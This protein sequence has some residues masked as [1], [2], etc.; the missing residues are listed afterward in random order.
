MKQRS[1]F[2]DSGNWPSPPGLVLEPAD[3]DESVLLAFLSVSSLC[4]L[5][6]N[7][8]I[9]LSEITA[10]PSSSPYVTCVLAQETG[11]YFRRVPQLLLPRF[12]PPL[13]ELQRLQDPQPSRFYLPLPSLMI[14]KDK[15]SGGT[16]NQ[17]RIHLQSELNTLQL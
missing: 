13:A 6:L 16:G 11:P 10:A 12:R 7:R 2:I 1:S 3:L 8:K 14:N 9:I 4:Q 17:T 5:R 15:V